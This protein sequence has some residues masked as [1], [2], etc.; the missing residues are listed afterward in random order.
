M[1]SPSRLFL[2]LEFIICHGKSAIDSSRFPLFWLGKLL[3]QPPNG[4]LAALSLRFKSNHQHVC[5]LVE[6]FPAALLEL[7]TPVSSICDATFG[8]FDRQVSD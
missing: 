7:N 3:E 4:Q 1:S 8:A 2:F 5:W 6:L